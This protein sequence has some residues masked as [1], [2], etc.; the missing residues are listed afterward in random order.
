M[1]EPVLERLRAGGVTAVN[2]RVPGV[3][4]AANGLASVN[5]GWPLTMLLVLTV[6]A[7]GLA[8]ALAA[9]T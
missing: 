3:P 2:A 4:G 6:V 9:K 1:P 8:T 7:G 5:S